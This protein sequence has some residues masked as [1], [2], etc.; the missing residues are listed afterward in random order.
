MNQNQITKIIRE[1][2][3]SWIDIA[4]DKYESSLT[5][6]IAF[7]KIPYPYLS[8]KLKGRT[9]GKASY[10]K[11]TIKINLVL[12]KENWD[13]MINQTLPHEIAHLVAWHV[14]GQ[15]I[16]PHGREWK[17]IMRAFGKKPSRCHALDTTNSAVRT[18]ARVFTYKCICDIS[19]DLTI[20]RHRRQ[21]SGRA[22]Y[23][24]SKCKRSL[25]YIG[26]NARQIT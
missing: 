17:S 24:C 8:F 1:Q 16:K 13:D 10:Q 5:N 25:K 22:N 9:A 23:R 4:N 14:Y 12:L 6:S 3:D 18:M 15:C 19:H 21:Q 26:I 20:I 11:W 2:I 7:N